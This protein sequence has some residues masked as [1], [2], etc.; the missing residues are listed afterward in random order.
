MDALH[1]PEVVACTMS[2]DEPT[3]CLPPHHEMIEHMIEAFPDIRAYNDTYP[4]QFGQ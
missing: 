2:T 1:H 3:R 4:I